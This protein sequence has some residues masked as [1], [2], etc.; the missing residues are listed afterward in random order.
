MALHVDAGQPHRLLVAADRPD[1]PARD[2]PVEEEPGEEVEGDHDEGRD[3]NGAD[4]PAA[5][6]GAE[7]GIDGRL[8]GLREDVGRAA[9]D[10]HRRQGHDEG[11]KLE[12]GDEEAVREAY[13]QADTQEQRRWPRTSAS[14]S[15]ARQP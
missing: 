2:R 7:K 10:P 8:W 5:Q 6:Q 11:L 15:G 3:G 9:D 13:R 14:P 1:C 4:E 12:P